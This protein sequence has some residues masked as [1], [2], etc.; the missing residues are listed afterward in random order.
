LEKKTQMNLLRQVL[1]FMKFGL[2]KET[3]L[4]RNEAQNIVKY[5]KIRIRT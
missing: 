1:G 2:L 4:L 3:I 5:Q